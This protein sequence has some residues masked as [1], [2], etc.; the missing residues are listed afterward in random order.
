MVDVHANCKLTI[1][2][3]QITL[4]NSYLEKDPKDTDFLEMKALS[5]TARA[6]LQLIQEAKITDETEAV[7]IWHRLTKMTPENPYYLVQAVK[8][9]LRLQQKQEACGRFWLGAEL[10][11]PLLQKLDIDLTVREKIT[12]EILRKVAKHP[13]L[14]DVVEVLLNQDTKRLLVH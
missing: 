11:F 10:A 7:A 4:V 8:L 6:K 3:G 9:H 2:N 5:L 13:E 12:V 14:Q 1:L